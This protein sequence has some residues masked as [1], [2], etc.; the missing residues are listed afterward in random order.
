MEV[1]EERD[2]EED[3]NLTTMK[4]KYAILTR[5][6]N[7]PSLGSQPSID[8]LEGR[9]DMLGNAEM[10]GAS[11]ISMEDMTEKIDIASA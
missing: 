1:T 6:S 10:T 4:D 8:G 9:D 7:E 2:D 11:H 5:V 3:D